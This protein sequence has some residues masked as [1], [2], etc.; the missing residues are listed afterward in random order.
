MPAVNSVLVVGGGAAGAA[1]A[2][3]LADAGVAVE[4]A[5]INPSVTALGSGITL[6]GNALRVLRQLGVLDDCLALG[7]PF[8]QL[9]IRAPD[10]AA[11][12]VAVIDDL[13]FGGPD[14][15]STMGMYRPDLARILM[16]RAE[17]VGVKIRFSTAVDT[18]RQDP[19]G[20]DVRF[21]DG[22]SGRYDLVVGADGV[23]SDLRGALGIQLETR[24]V[25]LGAWRMFGPRP[26]DITAFNIIFGGPSHMASVCPT[27]RDS[28]YWV[29]LEDAR[30]R[31]GQSPRERLADFRELTH[32][33]HGPWDEARDSFVD[34][35]KLHYTWFETHLLDPPWHRGRV[36]LIGD[37]VH[38]CP[39][40]IAQGAAMG[41]EDATVLAEL[42]TAADRVD[43]AMW[44]AFSARRHARVKAV[45][46]ASAQIAQWTLD[47]VQGDV[48]AVTREIAT[49]VSQPA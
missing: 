15:P 12:V 2:I 34:P 7:Y 31:T 4:L 23:R 47:H 9:V 46:D 30:D 33:Y 48:P 19:D 5:E 28:A 3:L 39:P 20:V 29:I 22:T 27:S 13:A 14:L 35:A 25:G 44:A 42:L 6:Q 40:T 37:A 36:V 16:A 45:V 24:A 41:L 21:R 1:A 26:A 32:A 38:V 18:L 17:A 43:E 10:P 11:T 8:S 49:L